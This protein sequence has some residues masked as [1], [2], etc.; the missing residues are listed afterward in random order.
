MEYVEIA[1]NWLNDT[2]LKMTWLSD[3]ITLIVANVFKFPVNDETLLGRIGGSIQFFMY[4]S[5]KIMVLL[6]CLIF[7]FSYIESKFTPE[8]TK[9][10]LSKLK[11]LKGAV[12]GAL[13]GTVTP[14]CSCSSIPI[15]ISFI[16]AGLPMEVTFSFLISSPFVDLAST[17]MLASLFGW[18]VAI[19]YVVV[20]V[21]LAIIGGLII[22]RLN[23]EKYIEEYV[24]N[25]KVGKVEEKEPTKKERINYSK[26]QVKNIFVKVW[27]YVLLGVGIGAIIHNWI[28]QS[29]VETILGKENIFA[30]ILAA[31]VGIPMYADIFGTMPIAEA[32]VYKGSGIG[33]VLTFMMGV[34]A[35]SI[36]SMI[37]LKQ[38]MKPKLLGIFIGI[39]TVGIILI[40]YMFN[41]FSF[42]II[43]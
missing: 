28:P 36:P 12:I 42:L 13:L 37:M 24:F 14:F 6:C 27:K 25:M 21:L 43:Q 5:I 2:F 40:G 16:R 23:L 38:V 30:P 35:L 1:F 18:R 33:T 11:G 39:I 19:V 26:E 7:V 29:I 9:K 22:G 8:K 31:L 17:V 4:D 20:G 15:F 10:I 3:L 34:T 41:I 32:L